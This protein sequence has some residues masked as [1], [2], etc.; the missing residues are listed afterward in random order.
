MET[1][2]IT[3]LR[4]FEETTVGSFKSQIL[5]CARK[6]HSAFYAS[7]YYFDPRILRRPYAILTDIINAKCVWLFV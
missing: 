6:S 5:L 7:T 1:L 3:S 4:H 2:P